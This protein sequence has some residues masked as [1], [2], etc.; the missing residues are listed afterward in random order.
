MVLTVKM[1]G[2]FKTATVLS[3]FMK[4]YTITCH[5]RGDINVML[6]LQSCTDSLQIL[7]HSSSET[8]PTLS[9]GTCDVGK[10]KVEG[11]IVVIVEDFLAVNEEL[12]IG[13]KEEER[14]YHDINVEP[15]EVSYVCVY[16][17][18]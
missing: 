14:T 11:D 15:D 4:V 17:C 1:E 16:V 9:D 3:V 2:T 8:Y 10:V 18:Y 12:G 6:V 7:P 13:M 5:D